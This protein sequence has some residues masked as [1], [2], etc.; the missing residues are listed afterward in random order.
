MRRAVDYPAA[1][2]E[3]NRLFVEAV[4]SVN[5]DTPIPTCPG[6]TMRQLMRHVGRAHR[7][8][9]HIIS[10]RAD[11]S[12]DPR[13]VPNGR[14]PDGTGAA[15]EWLLASPAA[16]LGAVAQVGGPEVTVATFVGQRPAQWWTR[17]LLHE[18]TVHRA[19][20]VIAAAG[21]YEIAPEVAADG[22]DEWL[23]RLT[24]LPRRGDLPIEDG[25]AVTLTASDVDARWTIVRRG[26]GLELHRD[27]TD[28]IAVAQ[29]AGPA[30]DLFLA[31]FRRRE[32]KEAG[33][34]VEGDLNAWR[35]FLER[36]P[37]A[38]PGTE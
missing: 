14:P 17:R 26:N 33:C 12:L 6:W 18:S 20:A 10:S 28:S 24:E 34:S 15:R 27:A 30:T 9:A 13:S 36:T 7:W 5:P 22:I 4:F 31:L 29:L 1:L 8:A 3:Q 19:D 23:E 38:A 32:A 21:H 35:T 37:Y 25:N 16:L 11:V 2:I